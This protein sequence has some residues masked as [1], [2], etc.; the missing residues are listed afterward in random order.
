MNFS[1][2]IRTHNRHHSLKLALDSVLRQ[3]YLPREVFVL[4]DL[5]QDTVKK[6]INDFKKKKEISFQYINTRNEFNS[7]KNLNLISTKCSSE[8]L[9]FL[10]DDD[11]WHEKY[12]DEANKLLKNFDIIYSN[13]YEVINNVKRNFYIKK[14]KFK[15]NI[16]SNNGYIISNLV[17]KK[18][19]FHDL[20]CFDHTLNSSADKDF[21]LKAI[22]KNKPVGFINK[23]YV[24][25]FIDRLDMKHNWSNDKKKILIATIFFFKKYFFKIGII[26]N[27]RMILKIIKLI[28]KL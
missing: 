19:T 22:K 23:F 26:L 25:Y 1:V 12:L 16:L 9:A 14:K 11:T 24:N 13:Y 15:E 10:D 8:Y 4:D 20:E 6:L 3:K 5:N 2:L 7:L 18:K 27:I 28:L 21:Y 17:V